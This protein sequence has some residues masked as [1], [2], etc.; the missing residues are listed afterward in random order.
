MGQI[1]TFN[2]E[3]A[4]S[5]DLLPEPVDPLLLKFSEK[6][7]RGRWT[8]E[9]DERL[10]QAVDQYDG[11]NWKRIATMAF[12]D[13]KTDV[14]CLHRWQKVLRPGLVKGPWT[15][16]ED[17]L[18]VQLVTRYGLKKWSLIA[19]H[20]RGRLGKQCRERWFN[21][22]NPDIKK[23][24]WT[25]EE[26]EIILQAHWELGNKWAQ[27]AARLPGRTDNAI[28]NRWNSTLQRMIITDDVYEEEDPITKKKRGRPKSQNSPPR[29]FFLEPQDI[30]APPAKKISAAANL[31][32]TP[33]ESGGDENNNPSALMNALF[34][35]HPP[36]ILRKASRVLSLKPTQSA[37]AAILK[38][39][40]Q[41]RNQLLSPSDLERPSKQRCIRIDSSGSVPSQLILSTGSSTPV[42]GTGDLLYAQA[43]LMMG[44]L[45]APTPQRPQRP[46]GRGRLEV[47][48]EEDE[49]E[50]EESDEEDEG[51]GLSALRTATV[52]QTPEKF[53]N[54]P[55]ASSSSSLSLVAAAACSSPPN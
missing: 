22:L 55:L 46:A 38:D 34:P 1:D 13:T 28:K 18:V 30:A 54:N 31:F 20:L 15:T 39:A 33:P 41:R 25:A 19:S 7:F 10:R 3:P 14:Q 36:S 2:E 11:K 40:R 12:G 42:K 37:I 45:S 51:E 24:A 52:L 23:D 27:I 32:P 5:D 44:M 53:R 47:Y 35:V 21:H 29:D 4:E 16:E 9:E 48:E 17:L 50:G 49:D 6:K 26:D 43:E 8:P